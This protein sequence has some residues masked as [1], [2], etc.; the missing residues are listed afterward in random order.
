MSDPSP[1]ALGDRSLFPDLEPA[2][3]LNH[4]AVSPPSSAVR[5][6]VREVLDAYARQGVGAVMRW[7]EQR[8]R[9]KQRLA[10]LIG[11]APSD[12][13]LV[14]N[15]TTGVLDVALCLP[16]RPGQGVVVFDGEFPTNVTPWQQAART[17]DLRLHRLPLSGFGDGSG[18]GLARVEATLAAGGVRLIA[19]SAVQFQTGLGMPLAQ[20]SALA[21]AHGAQL[22]V[23][24]IQ[25][26]G[27]VPIDVRAQGIDYLAAGSH[28][29]LMGLEGCG[30]L[31]VAPERAGALV[32]RIA[33]WLSHEEPLSF[34]FDGPGHLRYDRPVR[35]SADFVEV[36]APNT[37]G[38]AALEASV[39]LLSE[40]TIPAIHAHVQAYH[41][42]L[43]P[44]LIAR[45][46]RS[47][48]A[49]APG[50]RSGILSARPPE[51]LDDRAVVAGL[52]D[53]GVA[54]TNPDGIVRFSP[55]WPNGLHE[56]PAI[57]SALD[58]LLA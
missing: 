57:L 50:A 41:D 4:A 43:E 18:D 45:G 54:V 9:L 29:W 25:A 26:V 19:V 35:A 52:A 46:F 17:F 23:D 38:F 55:H 6:A 48:R 58:A 24:G 21:H 39:A 33:G 7:V 12:L 15:T 14:A 34:L 49:S 27:V 28:K 42:A 37:A 36:G 1:P 20:L 51:A 30:F 5:A 44:G 53:H 8:E 16:W 32:P 31:Y 13:G 40:L 11:A 56:I 22:F 10:A 3:Y 2:V 47:L